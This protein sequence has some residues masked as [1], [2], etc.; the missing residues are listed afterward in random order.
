M[1]CPTTPIPPKFHHNKFLENKFL[2]FE[3]S[4]FYDQD[5]PPLVMSYQKLPSFAINISNIK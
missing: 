5:L 3:E 2:D 1:G 4:F